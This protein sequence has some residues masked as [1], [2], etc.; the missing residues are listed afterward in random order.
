MQSQ[1]NP[2]TLLGLPTEIRFEIYTLL[3]SDHVIS[4]FDTQSHRPLFAL[5][6]V[7]ETTRSDILCWYTDHES[8][9]I[10]SQLVKGPFIPSLTTFYFDFRKCLCSDATIRDS[11]TALQK[12][13]NVCLKT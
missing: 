8:K 6:N 2:P 10:S 12:L 3:A 7:C 4:L 13:G 1:H 9:L 11:C 5:E